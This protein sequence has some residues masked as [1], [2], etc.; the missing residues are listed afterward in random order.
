MSK[1]DN[2]SLKKEMAVISIAGTQYIVH[3]G[4]Y[5]TVDHAKGYN[6]GDE[7]SIPVICK[8]LPS[9]ETKYYASGSEECVKA[10]VLQ[11]QKAKK[12]I[13]FKMRRRKHSRRKRGFRATQSKLSILSV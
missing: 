4:S 5:I 9:G 10:S 1:D 3:A 7:L 11:H 12:V 8:M 13:I 6:P 2:V